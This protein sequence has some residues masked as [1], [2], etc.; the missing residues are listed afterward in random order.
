MR[1]NTIFWLIFSSKN[2]GPTNLTLFIQINW[3]FIF[4]IKTKLKNYLEPTIAPLISIDPLSVSFTEK[5]LPN[6]APSGPKNEPSDS[7]T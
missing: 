5:T 7:N 1:V 3:V 6:S 4:K 2:I